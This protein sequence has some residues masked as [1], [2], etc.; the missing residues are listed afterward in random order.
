[1]ISRKPVPDGRNFIWEST[2]PNAKHLSYLFISNP[3][4]LEMMESDNLGNQ[5]FWD[6][7]PIKECQM[8]KTTPLDTKHTEL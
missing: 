6:S 7:L 8:N 2:K 5:K 1:L 3:N 4:K